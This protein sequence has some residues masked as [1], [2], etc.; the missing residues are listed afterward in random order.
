MPGSPRVCDWFVTTSD[1]IRAPGGIEDRSARRAWP[2]PATWDRA[3][4][5]RA[6]PVSHT[7]L[8]RS[9]PPEEVLSSITSYVPPVFG[10]P[11]ND[12]A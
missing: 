5:S 10:S 1:H 12:A 8:P 11:M 6:V 3:F 7:T 2:E 4:T 9:W